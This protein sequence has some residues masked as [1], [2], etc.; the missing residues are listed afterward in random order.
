MGT[1]EWK[2]R[3]KLYCHH[4]I[5][6]LSLHRRTGFTEVQSMV[7][8]G[9]LDKIKTL[10]SSRTCNIEYYCQICQS[11]KYKY[12]KFQAMRKNQDI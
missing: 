5:S 10:K 12:N 1:S 4:Y 2:L 11:V 9:N 7:E 3:R 8:K 6:V